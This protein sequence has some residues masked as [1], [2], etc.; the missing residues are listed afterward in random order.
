M[1][2]IFEVW[3]ANMDFQLV[4][5]I[6]KVVDYLTKYVT[7]QEPAAKTS[8]SKLLKNILT[9]QKSN[10]C[11]MTST[12]KRIMTKLLGC[13]AMSQQEKCHLLLSLPLVNSSH[14]FVRINLMNDSVKLDISNVTD[15]NDAEAIPE[16]KVKI[17][18]IM[19]VMD[20]YSF[21]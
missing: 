1:R 18:T 17:G 9:K 4:V 13:R 5:D 20:A 7:K 10:N 14:S 8:I 11:N 19:T 21:L 3:N 12:L 16:V 2:C 15:S 6:G